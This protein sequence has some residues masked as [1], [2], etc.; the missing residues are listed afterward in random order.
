MKEIAVIGFGV[1]GGGVVSLLDKNAA[2]VAASVGE[3]VRVKYILD[4]REFPD[5]PYADRV[6]H[7]PEPLFTDPDVALIVET[8]GGVKPAFEY[9][10][11]ALAA[12]KHVVTSNKELV[13]THGVELTK[14]AAEHGVAYLY[15]A[16]VGGGIP[17]IRPMR[18]SLAGER[19][20]AV[21]G[22]L[23][24]TTNYI[25][26]KM[27]EESAP[28]EDALA[29]AQR[30]GYAERDPSADVHG[31]DA[32]RKLMILTAVSTGFLP[33]VDDVYTETMTKVTPRDMDAARRAGCSVKLVAS[34]KCEGDSV[35]LSVCPR[36]VPKTDPLYAVDDVYNAVQVTGA[37][38]G[39]VMFYGRGAG[40]FPT[41]GAVISDIV[42][43]LN[44]AFR[45]ERYAVW[46]PAPQGFVEPFAQSSSGWYLRL[47]K[48]T[49]LPVGAER[50]ESSPDGTAEYLTGPMKETDAAA[51]RASLGDDCLSAVRLL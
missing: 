1:V 35:A 24:G 2:A 6:I 9:T 50:L 23:N 15:E 10:S 30:L 34:M 27:R 51:F 46:Q 14:L 22:I 7:D 32:Q 47:K 12:G 48:E 33:V 5:S 21:N 39:D 45:T 37:E 44:G 43:A 8:M 19:I 26:T 25:L 36:F 13:A 16:S 49:S 29:E 11:R 41:A 40:R 3:A 42:A 18:T 20:S 31:I 38:T 28:F 17:L 4:L